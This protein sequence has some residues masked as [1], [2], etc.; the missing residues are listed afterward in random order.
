M[1]EIIHTGEKFYKCNK[2]GKIFCQK[3][4]FMQHER[5]HARRKHYQCNQCQKT[6]GLKSHLTKH[7]RINYGEKLYQCNQCEKTFGWMLYLSRHQTTHKSG[8]F[9]RFL[10]SKNLH[11]GK[12]LNGRPAMCLP[13]AIFFPL[14]YGKLSSASTSCGQQFTALCGDMDTCGEHYFE[15]WNV[16]ITL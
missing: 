16:T 14:S 7:E 3:S 12:M 8:D 6:F 13:K 5:I 15:V 1:H 11:V 4:Q 9:W 2:C 10:P